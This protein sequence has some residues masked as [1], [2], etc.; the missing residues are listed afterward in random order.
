MRIISI[1][2]LCLAATAGKAQLL[3][4]DFSSLATGNFT[5]NGW[6]QCSASATSAQIVTNNLS[7]P[8]YFV[9]N[10]ANGVDANLSGG[11]TNLGGYCKQFTN[12]GVEHIYA[13]FL[14]KAN[15]IVWTG[16][17]G[18]YFFT[19]GNAN[20]DNAASVF[21]KRT[22]AISFQLGIRKG[23]GLD[24]YAPVILATGTTHLVVLKYSKVAGNTNDVV[25]LFINPTV[26]LIEP[27][28][29]I[30]ANLGDP[31][32]VTNIQNVFVRLNQLSGQVPPITLDAIMVDTTWNG[33]LTATTLPASINTSTNNNECNMGCNGMNITLQSNTSTKGNV[34]IYNIN[35]QVV[36]QQPQTTIAGTTT[37][38]MPRLMPGIYFIKWMNNKSTVTIKTQIQ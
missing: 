18:Q 17:T 26:G 28:P 2:F 6:S 32:V 13:A 5:G 11:A 15:Q 8:N 35:G 16:T 30:T 21:F 27:T 33:V 4:E 37:I 38:N 20:I 25:S 1:L 29:N 9:T 34:Y 31:D 3:T 10:I 22:S 14:I 23:T 24:I 12:P 19:I 7:Y 36:Y